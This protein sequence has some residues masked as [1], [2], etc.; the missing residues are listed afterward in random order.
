[1]TDNAVIP[2]AAA[3]RALV[4]LDGGQSGA[5]A[6]ILWTTGGDAVHDAQCSLDAVLTDQPVVPQLADRAGAALRQAWPDGTPAGI[7][8][9]A[10]A[11][12]S[13][14]LAS[15]ASPD[16]LLQLVRPHGIGRVALAHDSVTCHVGALGGGPGVVVAAGTG[17]VT[18]AVGAGGLARVDGWGHTL[19]D[20]GSGF[21]IGRAGLRAVLR[22]HDGRGRPT[23]LTDVVTAD[24]VNLDDAYLV[25]QSDD[26]W[27][28]RVASYAKTVAGLAATDPVCAEILDRAAAALADAA[29]TALR[30]AGGL[31]LPGGPPVALVGKLF[32]SPLL[33]ERFTDLLREAVPDARFVTP[34]GD[35]LDGAAGLFALTPDNPLAAQVRRA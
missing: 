13:T 34:Q 2:G 6:R 27:V 3:G 14:G 11:A 33:R 8:E 31:A 28:K 17:V 35:A 7:A 24:F 15:T 23:A 30:R 12:G 25:L 32:G 16:D 9:I 4:A 10:L 5:R 26:H 19:G 18:L 20:A 21:W 1:M 22:A 29:I